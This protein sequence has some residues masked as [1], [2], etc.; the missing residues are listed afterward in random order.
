MYGSD[1]DRIQKNIVVMTISEI[2]T[3]INKL[4]SSRQKVDRKYHEAL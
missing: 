4:K 1:F 2:R 3:Q